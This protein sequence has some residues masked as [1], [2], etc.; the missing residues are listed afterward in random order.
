MGSFEPLSGL[1]GT[2][3]DETLEFPRGRVGLGDIIRGSTLNASTSES[4][5]LKSFI[6]GR[7]LELSDCLVLTTATTLL[8]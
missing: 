2:Y 7:D 5:G 1:M 6:G 4:V 3:V 8:R